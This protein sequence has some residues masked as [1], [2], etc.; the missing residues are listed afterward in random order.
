MTDPTTGRWYRQCA[1]VMVGQVPVDGRNTCYL[2]YGDWFAMLC[3]FAV[4]A[5][6]IRSF[7]QHPDRMTAVSDENGNRS[8]VTKA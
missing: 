8:L 4:V 7:V 5:V 3:G 6:W 1:A 2:F